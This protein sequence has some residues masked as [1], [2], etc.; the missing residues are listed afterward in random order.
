LAYT[1]GRDVVFGAGQYKPSSTE[2]KLLLAHELT[3]TIQQGTRNQ[4]PGLVQRIPQL[5][6]GAYVIFNLRNNLKSLA[7]NKVTDY[8]QYRNT[9]FQSSEIEKAVALATPELLTTLR[10]TLDYMSFTRC[11]EALGRKAPTFD[12][13]RKDS[14]VLQAINDAWQASDV[15]VRDLVAQPHEEGGWVFMN[16]ID[17]S[18]SI[19]RATPQYTDAIKVEPAPQVPDSVLVALFHTHPTLGP[20]AGPSPHDLREDKRRGVPNLVVANKGNDPKTFQ[21][22]LSGPAARKHLA[23]DYQFP[24]PSGGIAP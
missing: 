21:I 20:K 23:Y 3:H 22:Y 15:G 14:T 6:L 17:G 18:L 16:L 1:V 12:E 5:P 19:E 11:V 24:G 10:D 9:I 13:L 7:D 8:V 4:T 2:G